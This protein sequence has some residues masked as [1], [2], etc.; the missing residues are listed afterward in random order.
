MESPLCHNWNEVDENLR[1]M[2][3]NWPRVLF[4]YNWKT[5]GLPCSSVSSPA[6]YSVGARASS[7]W[8]GLVLPWTPVSVKKF[9]HTQ[10]RKKRIYRMRHTCA[11]SSGFCH[12]VKRTQ[13]D[14]NWLSVMKHTW[15][16]NSSLNIENNVHYTVECK[17]PLPLRPTVAI[18][19]RFW[20]TNYVNGVRRTTSY[21][22]TITI[23]L[24]LK[25]STFV[26]WC[27][28]AHCR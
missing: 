17:K 26:K 23:E 7:A 13:C 25:L 12:G 16:V 24:Q 8:W 14:V 10:W 6:S 21:R 18:N 9:K 2:D 5:V 28:L 4:G 11:M 27:Q 20:D 3:V 15:A 22:I 19:S 1:N